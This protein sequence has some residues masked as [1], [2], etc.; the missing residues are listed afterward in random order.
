M[1]VELKAG[2]F[3]PEHTGQLNFY[4]SAVDLQVKSKHDNPTIGLLLCKTQNRVVAEYSLRDT[5]K[6]WLAQVGY[7]RVKEIENPELASARA[8]DLY[9]TKCYPQAW[10][11]KRLCSITICGELTD[12]WKARGVQEG[13]MSHFAGISS[14]WIPAFAGMTEYL[15]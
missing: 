4:L 3:K 9:Q 6:R 1:V 12:E 11:E 10:I 14:C 15:S 13:N 5:N 8:R 7:E 2:A